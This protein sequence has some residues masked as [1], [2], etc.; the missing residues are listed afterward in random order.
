[1]SNLECTICFEEITG[2]TGHVQMSCGHF[3]HFICLTRWFGNQVLKD[4]VETCPCCRHEANNHEGLPDQFDGEAHPEAESESESES[5]LDSESDSY[6]EFVPS[7]EQLEAAAFFNRKR[8]ELSEEAFKSYA[9]TRI[10][11]AMRSYHLRMNWIRY[12]MMLDEKSE[13]QM[14]AEAL[15]RALKEADAERQLFVKSM[16][17]PRSEWRNLCAIKLQ[18]VWRGF[19]ERL[20]LIGRALDAGHTINWTFDGFAW[21]RSFLKR[22][23]SWQPADGL[24]PQSLMFQNHRMW[25]KVQ[26]AWRAYVV[27][28]TWRQH[29]GKGAVQ[30]TMPILNAVI[31]HLGG[32]SLTYSEFRQMK[33]LTREGFR[34]LCVMNGARNPTEIEWRQAAIACSWI[35]A[36]VEEELISTSTN[37]LTTFV[38]SLKYSGLLNGWNICFQYCQK[39]RVVVAAQ[40]IQKFWIRIR[41]TVTS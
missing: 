9:A 13:L 40:A 26:A 22:Q 4:L 17:M 28:K 20:A 16:T 2:A 18:T 23:E 29:D 10:Q 30:F 27:R 15:Q 14:R 35:P 32:G 33:P 3:F 11:A 1:M 5:E 21:K 34:D 12:R 24:A 8:A 39:K 38:P 41:N 37:P 36:R 25:T 7:A 19:R 31:M 6:D